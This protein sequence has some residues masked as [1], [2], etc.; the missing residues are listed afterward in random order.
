[1]NKTGIRN[2]VTFFDNDDAGIKATNRFNNMIR[3][4]T[5]VTNLSAKKF[6]KKDINDLTIQE[7]DTILDDEGLFFR[8]NR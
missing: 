5:I 4:D 6:G 8:I 3:K 7:F 2:W 1:L